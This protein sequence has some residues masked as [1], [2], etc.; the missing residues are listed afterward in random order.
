M[1]QRCHIHKLHPWTLRPLAH[2]TF[3]LLLK[4]FHRIVITLEKLVRR[5]P[6]EFS[7]SV[8]VFTGSP[9]ELTAIVVDSSG[10]T[11]S[12]KEGPAYSYNRRMCCNLASNRQSHCALLQSVTHGEMAL[13][14]GSHN[15]RVFFWAKLA[16]SLSTRVTN[17]C[18]LSKAQM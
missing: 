8:S 10:C 11:A 15:R 13:P 5:G 1:S 3:L 9:L 17:D 12:W 7:W 16:I 2:H 4:A 18:S 14:F 6:L